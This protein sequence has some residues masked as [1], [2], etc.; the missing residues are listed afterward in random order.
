MLLNRVL[1][2][3]GLYFSPFNDGLIARVCTSVCVC[4][5]ENAARFISS[6]G[7]YGMILIL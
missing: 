7:S 5:E 6:I 1:C 4:L 2:V 3:T